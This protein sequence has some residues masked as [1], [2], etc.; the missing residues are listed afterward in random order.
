MMF[1]EDEALCVVD[2]LK[3]KSGVIKEALKKVSSAGRG[4]ARL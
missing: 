4:G 2:L 3:E 1:S